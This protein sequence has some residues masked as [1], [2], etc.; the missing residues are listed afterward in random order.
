MVR[1]G[2]I[3]AFVMVALW[4][5]G[6]VVGGRVAGPISN[7]IALVLLV[8]VLIA[9][10]AHLQRR[11]F[12]EANAYIWAIVGIVAIVALIMVAFA[13][14]ALRIAGGSASPARMLARIGA[15]A[16]IPAL[17]AIGLQICILLLGTKLRAYAAAGGGALWKA[18]GTVAI[19]S[20]VL[21]LVGV[22]LFFL[23]A[24]ARAGA[25]GI[26]AT[27]VLGLGGLAGMAFWI[28]LGIG[29]IKGEPPGSPPPS[30]T[31]RSLRRPEAGLAQR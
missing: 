18:T 6:G 29:L 16:I 4:I 17:L 27:I 9:L 26:P 2:G 21:L 19:A 3:S 5:L 28:S 13:T 10:S 1:A 22:V 7:L 12:R 24:L 31:E 20:A 11:N 30:L 23:G 15:W 8:F 25:L 14:G